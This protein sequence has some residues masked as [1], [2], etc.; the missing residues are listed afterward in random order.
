MWE[1]QSS[2]NISFPACII[3]ITIAEKIA[4]HM[5]DAPLTLQDM[6]E[7]AMTPEASL[8]LA[9]VVYIGR[10]PKAM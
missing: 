2:E 8:W 9:E 3:N 5:W 6:L 1:H 7:N 10:P 4:K